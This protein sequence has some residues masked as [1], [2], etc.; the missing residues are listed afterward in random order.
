MKLIAKTVLAAFVGVIAYGVWADRDAGPDY[1][2][3][4]SEAQ[5]AQILRLHQVKRGGGRAFVEAREEWMGQ[6]LHLVY[7]PERVADGTGWVRTYFS[8]ARRLMQEVEAAAPGNAYKQ[9]VID[10]RLPTTDGSH[11]RG[12]L[13]QYDWERLRGADLD[14]YVAAIPAEQIE[15]VS[16]QRLGQLSASEYCADPKYL[17]QTPRFCALATQ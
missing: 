10:V 3:G 9:L 17:E 8:D 1:P 6:R 13:V 12:M 2:E 11:A 14:S 5:K 16:F 15:K 4:A 7:Q